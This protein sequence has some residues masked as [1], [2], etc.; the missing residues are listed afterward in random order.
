MIAMTMSAGATTDA[1]LPTEPPVEALTTPAPAATRTRKKVP[2][3]S[4]NS[5]RHSYVRSEKSRA[6]A[7]IGG[8]TVILAVPAGAAWTSSTAVGDWVPGGEPGPALWSAFTAQ[9]V[10]KVR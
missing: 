4:P 6:H 5:R 10:A 9:T 7:G 3:T 1:V 2:I 8:P